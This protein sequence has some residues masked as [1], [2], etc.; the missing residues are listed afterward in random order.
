[1]TVTII[2]KFK[3]NISMENLKYIL[4]WVTEEYKI[5]IYMYVQQR[6]TVQ[7]AEQ[8]SMSIDAY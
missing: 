4:K 8:S 1:M 3:D 5:K 6:K 7:N 2:E